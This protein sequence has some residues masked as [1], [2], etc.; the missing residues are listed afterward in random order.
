MVFLFRLR[1]PELEKLKD[2]GGVAVELFTRFKEWIDGDRSVLS[3]A[4]S[5]E[6]LNRYDAEGLP[7]D[8][9]LVVATKRVKYG[10]SK[11]HHETRENALNLSAWLQALV[12]LGTLTVVALQRRA[13]GCFVDKLLGYG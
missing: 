12:C 9:E 6:Q 2:C 7:Y 11:A 1:A 8:A 5:L 10:E 3:H 4:V 13:I